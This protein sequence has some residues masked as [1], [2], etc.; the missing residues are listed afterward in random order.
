MEFM[1]TFSEPAETVE[2]YGDPATAAAAMAPWMAYMGEMAGAGVLR[3]G[4]QLKPAWTAT[5]VRVRDG[6]RLVQDGP[7]A[8]TKELVGGYVIIDVP[9]LDEALAWA[10]RSPSSLSGSTEVRPVAPRA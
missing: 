7:F 9:T 8:D 5:T 2:R 3:G 4:N 10:E 1:L 6:R